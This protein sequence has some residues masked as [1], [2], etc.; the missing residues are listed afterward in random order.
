[1]EPTPV[2]QTFEKIN[3]TWGTN[4]N[5]LDDEAEMSKFYHFINRWQLLDWFPQ[6]NVRCMLAD[7]AALSS[8][9][10]CSVR[11]Y[12]SRELAFVLMSVS[13]GYN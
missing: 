2:F 11:N 5:S 8:C 10:T 3:V 9:V 12:A 13:Y 7:L 4:M 6:S 1:M